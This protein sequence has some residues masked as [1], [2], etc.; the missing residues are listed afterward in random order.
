MADD[1]VVRGVPRRMTARDVQCTASAAC[2]DAVQDALAELFADA[3]EV[4]GRDRMLFETALVE[5]MGNLVEHARTPADEPVTIDVRVA[6]HPDRIEAVLLDDGVAPPVD[7]TAIVPVEDLAES[8]RGLALAHAVSEVTH[9][10]RV[11]GGNRWT[12]TRRR[13]V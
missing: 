10:C 9:D 4:D 12:V 7:P 8:G 3:P 11:G 2:L 6:V 1:D 5:I 13:T